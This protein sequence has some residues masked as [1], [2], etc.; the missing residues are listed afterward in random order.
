[1]TFLFETMSYGVKL[2]ALCVSLNFLNCLVADCVG[3]SGSLA[4]LWN[5]KISCSI[6]PYS[7]N[8]IDMNAEDG[9]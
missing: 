5:N 8:H 1:M 2:E 3:R 4:I 7:N 6:L 9:G